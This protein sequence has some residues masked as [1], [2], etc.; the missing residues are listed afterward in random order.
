MQSGQTALDY[1]R[2]INNTALVSAL[3]DV[4]GSSDNTSLIYKWLS[5]LHLQQYFPAF[6][7]QGFDD[8]NFITKYGKHKQTHMKLYCCHKS[9]L[10]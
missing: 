4:S 8:I 9:K 2:K 1:A 6:V 10:M 3:T 5:L 7:A